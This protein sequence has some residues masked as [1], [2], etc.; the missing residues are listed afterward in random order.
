MLCI[1]PLMFI[2]SKRPPS[3]TLPAGNNLRVSWLTEP[4]L[5][6][7]ARRAG[8]VKTAVVDL[9]ESKFEEIH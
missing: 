4:V 7:A 1:L 3:E 9:V 8:D 5:I 2:R 6:D